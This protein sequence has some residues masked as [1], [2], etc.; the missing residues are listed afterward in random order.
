MPLSSADVRGP[1]G[2]YAVGCFV[3]VFTGPTT[4]VGTYEVD[5]HFPVAGS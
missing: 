3:S 1:A 4:V 5:A 2:L